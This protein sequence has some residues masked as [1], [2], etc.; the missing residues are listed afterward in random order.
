M[1]LVQHTQWASLGLPL[2]W[3][4]GE[5]S[6]CLNDQVPVSCGGRVGVR[7]RKPGC[8]LLL[9]SLSHPIATSHP[10]KDISGVLS[11]LANPGSASRADCPSSPASTLPGRKQRH[12]PRGA[13][14]NR[15]ASDFESR[16]PHL[17]QK[18]LVMSL[19]NLQGMLSAA[20]KCLHLYFIVALNPGLYESHG[21]SRGSQQ[22]YNNN[23]T[24]PKDTVYEG[25]LCISS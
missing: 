24:L 19:S 3:V 22:I 25:L 9:G 21:R 20:S 2:Q 15:L 18:R 11:N 12:A 4:W 16:T 17:L 5:G 7:C 1:P 13:K 14:T 6:G 8:R 23:D 10:Q